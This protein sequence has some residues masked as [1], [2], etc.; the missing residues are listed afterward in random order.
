M[1]NA[2]GVITSINPISV[3]GMTLVDEKWEVETYANDIYED[4]DIGRVHLFGDEVHDEPVQKAVKALNT[5]RQLQA[6]VEPR[7]KVNP[8]RIPEYRIKP[9]EGEGE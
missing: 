3:V 8:V 5:Y 1:Y 9:Q 4:S 6:Y 7:I 2:S